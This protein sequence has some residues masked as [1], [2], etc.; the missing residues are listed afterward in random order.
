VVV[1]QRRREFDPEV[2]CSRE[3]EVVAV[4]LPHPHDAV[5][6]LPDIPLA[7]LRVEAEEL[8]DGG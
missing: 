7:L 6:T 4:L 8:G 5:L 1:V 2:E 3:V